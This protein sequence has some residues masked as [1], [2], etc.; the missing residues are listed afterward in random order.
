[1]TRRKEIE[2]EKAMDESSEQSKK[3][4]NVS[5]ATNEPPIAESK[6]R[7][8]SKGSRSKAAKPPVAM[9]LFSD[10]NA[11]HK[12]PCD[13]KDTYKNTSN[14]ELLVADRHAGDGE[15]R[16]PSLANT[17]LSS[18]KPNTEPS[19]EQT[20]V[21]PTAPAPFGHISSTPSQQTGDVQSAA[22]PSSGPTKA[23]GTSP[24]HEEEATKNSLLDFYSSDPESGLSKIMNALP[25]PKPGDKRPND[26][27]SHD[28]SKRA[29]TNNH[30]LTWQ[31]ESLMLEAD[32][33]PKPVQSAEILHKPS[34]PTP[35]ESD[36]KQP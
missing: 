26:H 5:P 29:L 15:D 28:D 10:T 36:N 22:L 9:A 16:D 12:S 14:S 6:T 24:P 30:S 13:P 19:Q 2:G 34:I 11:P 27:S 7:A 17:P 8:T 3:E 33:N 4:T 25:S 31:D 35:N 1:M 18:S 20:T 21:T 23:P 32:R